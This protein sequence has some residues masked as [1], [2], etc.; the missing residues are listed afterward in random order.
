[1]E[2]IRGRIRVM[3][4]VMIRVKIIGMTIGIAFLLAIA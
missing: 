3:P 4:R 1:M 2:M